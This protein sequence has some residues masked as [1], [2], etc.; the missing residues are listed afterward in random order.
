M[1]VC[2][3]FVMFCA[4]AQDDFRQKYEEFKR[5]AQS[6][7]LSFRDEANRQYAEF[8][9]RAWSEARF[10]P[11]TPRPEEKDRPPVVIRD[12]ER[13]APVEENVLPVRDTVE[14]PRPEPQPHP[15]APIEEQP[16]VKTL[17]KSFFVYGTEMKVCFSDD[18]AFSLPNCSEQSVG[19]AWQLLSEPKYNNLVR[20]CLQLRAARHLN[21]WA[22]LNMLWQM[23]AACLSDHNAAT[24]LAAYVYSQSGYQMRIA[25]CEGQL[26]VL[27]ASRHF[28]YDRPYVWIGDE[29]YLSFSNKQ[30]S[31]RVCEAEFPQEKPM[32]LYVNEPMELNEDMS[33]E[34]TLTSA[35]YPEM[36]VSVKINKNV[37][38]FCNSYPTSC[39]DDNF[40][41]RWAMY[42]SKPMDKHLAEDLYP[43]LRKIIKGMTEQNAVEHLLNWVQTA[44]VYEFDDVVWGGDRAFFAEETLYYPYCDCEDRSILFSR[45]VRDLL[46]L[47]V[48][49]IYYPGH[50]ATAVCFTE[51]IK[52][53]YV[54]YGGRR[55]V[56]CDGTYIGAHIG[57]TMPGMDNAEAVIILL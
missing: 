53:D 26:E 37:I 24:L 5:Q 35:R 39:V 9:R 51:E 23:A 27:C 8:V 50:L 57:Q 44:L 40:M 18:M 49:L 30:G 32:S 25:E 31:L 14:L 15:V 36:S 1:A 11:G 48:V 46:G 3:M 38:D 43:A 19:D 21:D 6:R 56:V 52:G 54:T 20:D 41:T 45:L 16:Q 29:R 42:A 13:A 7:Y 4:Y 28:M 12:E 33:E 17:Y 2:T 34:R 22:Y 10:L 47:D 55:F